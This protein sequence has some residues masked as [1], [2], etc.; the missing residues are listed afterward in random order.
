[1]QPQ[2]CISCDTVWHNNTPYE[3]ERTARRH[4][5]LACTS[6]VVEC[7]YQS[8]QT[9]RIINI[10]TLAS[11]VANIL[12]GG[13]LRLA[14]ILQL[15]PLRLS[16]TNHLQ[17]LKKYQLYRK[18]HI[19]LYNP[20]LNKPATSTPTR[21]IQGWNTKPL[22]VPMSMDMLYKPHLT[23]A[24]FKLVVSLV[25]YNW[26]SLTYVVSRDKIACVGL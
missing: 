12:G 1:M 5:S 26:V 18:S 15:H 19:S 4:M 25:Y 3:S 16:E 11:H 2:M 8:W 9:R 22:S 10:L 23:Y 21:Y 7:D 13:G 6:V 17:T 14:K 24:I 20:D